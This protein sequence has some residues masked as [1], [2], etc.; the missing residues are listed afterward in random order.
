V[1]FVATDRMG[2]YVFAVASYAPLD[3]SSFENRDYDRIGGY[4][5]FTMANRSIARRPDVFVDRFAARVLWDVDTPYDYDVDYYFPLGQPGIL[6]AYTMCGSMFRSFSSS[7]YGMVPWGGRLGPDGLSLPVHVLS[8]TACAASTRAV[9]F[10][11]NIGSV[12]VTGPVVP[13]PEGSLGQRRT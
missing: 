2:G 6:N 7:A 13:I 11:C 4:S 1:A 3:F 8:G 5:R 12:V 9:T 10:R